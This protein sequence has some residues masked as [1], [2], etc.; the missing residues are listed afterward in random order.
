MHS[1]ARHWPK[2][3]WTLG[4]IVALAAVY[5]VAPMPFEKPYIDPGLVALLLV[6]LVCHYFL[7]RSGPV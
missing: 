2:P 7:S 4:I 5:I 3:L 6:V 1:H